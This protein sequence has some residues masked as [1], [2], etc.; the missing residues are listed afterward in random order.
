MQQTVV[1]DRGAQRSRVVAQLADLGRRLV[2]ER[3][4]TAVGDSHR[5]GGVE[6]VL[7]PG[8][9]ASGQF[10]LVELEPVVPDEEVEPGRVPPA[11]L[12]PVDRGQRQL[13][14]VEAGQRAGTTVTTGQGG[15]ARRGAQAVPP[16]RPQHVLGS[17]QRGVGLLDVGD[18]ERACASDDLLDLRLP[19]RHRRVELVEPGFDGEDQRGAVG[20]GQ[21]AGD[22]TEQ[23]VGVGGVVGD[24]VQH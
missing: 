9:E 11:H 6:R 18:L 1:P 24:S 23:R 4:D 12:Q 2:H 16:Q 15:H 21:H 13:H 7:T 3:Q 17:Y 14:G 22:A 5:A 10:G 8:G 20:Q 19:R